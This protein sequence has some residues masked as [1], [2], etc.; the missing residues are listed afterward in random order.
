MTHIKGGRNGGSSR[1]SECCKVVCEQQQVVE[2][3]PRVELK[4]VNKSV[5]VGLTR[6]RP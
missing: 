1:S 3:H 4:C 5:V 6:V 2:L